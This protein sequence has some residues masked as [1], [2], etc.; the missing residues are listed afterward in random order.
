MLGAY[1]VV[2]YRNWEA[3]GN[4]FAVV[5]ERN[6]GMRWHFAAQ[7]IVP[8]NLGASARFVAECQFVEVAAEEYAVAGWCLRG[9]RQCFDRPR[10]SLRCLR[11]REHSNKPDWVSWEDNG[12]RR[13]STYLN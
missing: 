6:F 8:Y 3:L 9:N 4:H 12:W 7:G 11:V 5:V 1:A 10:R 13:R 2:A